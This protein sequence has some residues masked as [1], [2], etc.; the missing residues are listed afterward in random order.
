MSPEV[1]AKFIR[2]LCL[3]DA[4]R[5][6][7]ELLVGLSAFDSAMIAARHAFDQF[8]FD[9]G[10]MLTK[11]KVFDFAYHAGDT[12][13][14]TSEELYDLIEDLVRRPQASCAIRMINCLG[15]DTAGS[16]LSFIE[17]LLATSERVSIEH[18]AIFQEKAYEQNINTL[19]SLLP[20]LKY[21]CYSVYYSPRLKAIDFYEDKLI[22]DVNCKD[23][24]PRYFFLSFHNQGLSRCLSTLDKSV[25]DFWSNNYQY[26]KESHGVLNLDYASFDVFSNRLLELQQSTNYYLLKPNFCYDDIPMSVYESMRAKIPAQEL[27]AIEKTL[28]LENDEGGGLRT[29]LAG[30]EQR[31]ATSYTNRRINLHSMNGLR[32]LAISGR[33]SDHLTFMPPFDK[34]QL[35]VIFTQARDRNNDGD[36]SYTLLITRKKILADGYILSAFENIGV[37][38]EYNQDKYKQDIASSLFIKNQTLAAIL[39]DYVRNHIPGS[40]ALTREET[41]AFLNS[42]IA[43]LE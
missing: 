11:P 4:E 29:L 14:R 38:V 15:K 35:R 6:E 23:E 34:E 37:M 26:F 18:L 19:I 12:L 24:P 30:I 40:H 17:K 25:F 41:T 22:I 36:D 39:S 9:Q 31:R 7:F 27:D 21:Q 3:D 32:Q 42:L 10:E 16:V 20:L 13:L 1:Q 8:V 5:R 33:L 28:C 2:V 43:S